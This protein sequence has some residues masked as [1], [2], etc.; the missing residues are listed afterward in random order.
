VR[1]HVP[2][3][4]VTNTEE[5]VAFYGHHGFKVVTSGETP[6]HGPPAW[7]MRRAP[8]AGI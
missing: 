6:R 2:C 3:V 1:D 4:L 7:V 8:S 5:N